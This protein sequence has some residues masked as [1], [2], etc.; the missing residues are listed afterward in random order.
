MSTKISSFKSKMSKFIKGKDD[1]EDDDFTYDYDE[2]FEQMLSELKKDD[3]DMSTTLGTGTFG[4]VR[5]CRTANGDIFAMKIMQKSEIVRLKQVEHV[6]NER[7]ILL[8]IRHPFIVNLFKTFQDESNLYMLF[9]YVRGGELFHHLRKNR[10]FDVPRARYYAAEIVLAIQ[11]L[12]SKNVIYRDLKPENLLLDHDGHIKI[13]DFGFAKNVEYNKTFTFCGTAEYVAPEIIR[14]KGYG[15]SV[16]WWCVGVLI[17]EML[18]GY[19]PF[20][21]EDPFGI[22]KQILK[23]KLYFPSH[24]DVV[25]KD[26]IKKLLTVD[27]TKRLGNLKNGAEDIKKHPW[28]QGLNFKDLFHKEL[29]TPFQPT[30]S[31]EDDTSNFDDYPEDELDA[32]E[33][34]NSSSSSSFKDLFEAW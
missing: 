16:D 34:S 3:L 18:A 12:H 25:S 4:R 11:Y 23:G 15:K 7:E 22:Y 31:S 33:K 24:F 5:L 6:E 1:D 14:G 21:D 20:Y 26:L 10:R 28:F 17:Y 9:E 29:E 8:S 30:T 19:T 32:Q 2:E 13:T 27:L